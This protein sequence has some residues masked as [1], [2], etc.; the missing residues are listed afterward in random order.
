M[1]NWANNLPLQLKSLFPGNEFALK[2]DD[3]STLPLRTKDTRQS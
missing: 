2:P 1:Q 3:L